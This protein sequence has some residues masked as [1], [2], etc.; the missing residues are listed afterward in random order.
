MLSFEKLG[1]FMNIGFPG[2][3]SDLTS[4]RSK[5]VLIME[6]SIRRGLIAIK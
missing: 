3:L 2:T 1:Y 5:D 6:V 4:P